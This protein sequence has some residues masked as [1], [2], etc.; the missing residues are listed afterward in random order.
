MKEHGFPADFLEPPYHCPDCRDTGYIGN[1]RCHCL[2]QASIDL[3]YQQAN[4]KNVLSDE[5]FDSFSLS[6]YD[7]LITD[8]DVS[9]NARDNAKRIYDYCRSW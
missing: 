7:T 4:L 5:N 2:T 9:E 6:F 1:S 3:L 8:P